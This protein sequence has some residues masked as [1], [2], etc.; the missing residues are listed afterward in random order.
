MR[1]AATDN[2]SGR[3]RE[4]RERRWD[5]PGCTVAHV[6]IAS[7][8]AYRAAY[9]AAKAEDLARAAAQVLAD[10]L[11]KA[12]Y[13]GDFVERAGDGEFLLVSRPAALR[14][15]AARAQEVFDWLAPTYYTTEDAEQGGVRLPDPSGRPRLY[16]IARL[17][18]MPDDPY[19]E[20][21]ADRAAA[22]TASGHESPSPS[23]PG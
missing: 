17:L 11:A 14:A 10:A 3:R 19:K 8:G 12:G 9:G 7:L 2:V 6:C 23:H 4:E 5:R 18:V 21:D 22:A 20:L 15:A 1:S 13:H 16:P